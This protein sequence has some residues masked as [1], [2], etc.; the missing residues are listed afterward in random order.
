MTVTFDQEQL[1]S[2]DYTTAKTYILDAG[3]YY[4]TAAKNAHDAIN[5]ILAVKGK[6]V[7]D[8][9]TAEGNP[10]M[11]ATYT[12]TNGT[13]DTT[14]YA[15]DTTTGVAITNLLDDANGG[16]QYLSRQD[17]TGT[18]PTTDGEISD[19]ISTWGN[20]IN[21][22]DANG[23]PASYTYYKTISDEDLAKLDSLTL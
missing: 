6:T 3:D 17:W 1:K 20:Q 10:A 5:N 12:P 11:V 9:M 15:T 4:I 8:G 7:E 19:Q 14:T 16:L 2:Y 21:G 22:T 18:W 23:Q 13:V